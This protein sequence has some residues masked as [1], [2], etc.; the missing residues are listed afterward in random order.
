MAYYWRP[1]V[2]VA[3]RRAQA[4]R[5]METLRKKGKVIQPI[6]I[7]GRTIA[8]SF[9]GK[10]WCE[11]LES[12]S[13]FENRLPRGRT[14]VRNGSV[15]HLVIEPGRI[16]AMV[17]GSEL[18]NI[19]INIKPLKAAVWKAIK[20]QCSGQIGSMLEL[21]QGR[22]S[23]QVM[24]I[25]T[26]RKKGLLPL[27]GQIELGCN[28]PDWAA[29]CK[30]LAAVL[31]GVGS[32]LDRQPELLFTLRGVDANELITG[33]I[34]LPDSTATTGKTLA[35]DQLAD[36]FGV[37]I[38]LDVDVDKPLPARKPARKKRATVKA[39][40]AKKQEK[41]TL[42]HRRKTTV[43]KKKVKTIKVASRTKSP[44]RHEATGGNTGI[45]ELPQIRP[46]GQSVARLRRQLKLSVPKFAERLGTTPASIYRWEKTSG[47][48]KLQSQTFTGL[49]MLHKQ[50][51]E[52]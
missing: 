36:I 29:M 52:K 19:K 3:R 17:S 16:E 38:D 12:F 42:S 25:V 11:H 32:R 13:D 10:A 39:S 40:A 21:L 28:C 50:A 15:C 41:T 37:D 45:T 49:A 7:E 20:K 9:W 46:T 18:Y 33:D 8:R 1:Y 2:P 43:A 23:D 34:S 48:L 51:R 14:Y 6:E 44:E 31:Y 4:F 26:D 22:L 27:P 5:K 47:R 35:D 24:S 30:H